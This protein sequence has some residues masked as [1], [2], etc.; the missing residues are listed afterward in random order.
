MRQ[1][2]TEEK[3]IRQAYK[4][5]MPLPDKIKNKPQL[6]L[7]LSFMYKAFRELSTD[8]K[9]GMAEGPITW[10]SMNS[11]AKRHNILD[12][13][14]FVLLMQMVDIKYMEERNKKSGKT[15]G[16]IVNSSGSKAM[17]VS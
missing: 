14:Y 3:I 1:G 6:T 11:Y 16:K 15:K 4:M 8:R 9:I 7:G 10:S 12:F 13:D 17:G 2:P 5:N